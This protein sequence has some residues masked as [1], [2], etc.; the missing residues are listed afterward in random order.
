MKEEDTALRELV[1]AVLLHTLVPIDGR[2]SR[3]E[4]SAFS[5]SVSLLSL[6][7][8]SCYVL[9]PNRMKSHTVNPLS[10]HSE[11]KS[12][13]IVEVLEQQIVLNASCI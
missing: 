5:G 7:F 3:G 11:F 12:G 10:G 2:A 1:R 4:Q 8:F 9:V 13:Q 6:D